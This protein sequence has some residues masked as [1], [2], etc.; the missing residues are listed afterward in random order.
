MQTIAPLEL[1][2]LVNAPDEARHVPVATLTLGTEAG[3]HVYNVGNWS[4]RRVP[5]GCSIVEVANDHGGENTI[6]LT[7]TKSG[8]RDM[9]AAML[10]ANRIAT[11]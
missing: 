9:L 5:G 10:V 6:L 3:R 1:T 4:W 8:L 2:N 11:D 7:K